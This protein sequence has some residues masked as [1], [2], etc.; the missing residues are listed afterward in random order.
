[1]KTFTKIKPNHN[2]VWRCNYHNK[3]CAATIA[4]E[5]DGESYP[6]DDKNI[7]ADTVMNIKFSNGETDQV[8]A[9]DLKFY[10]HL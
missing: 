7:L 2:M 6:Q 4:Q 3:V 1:M 5:I 9:K 10:N 8:E